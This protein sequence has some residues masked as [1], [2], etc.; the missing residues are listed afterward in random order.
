M[1]I[2]ALADIHGHT[3]QIPLLADAAGA[4]DAIVV[5]GDVTNFGRTSQARSV[6]SALSAFDR[7]VLGVSGN[8]D[9]PQV[10]DLL[11]QQ[12]G[13]L[14]H[15]PVELN[16]IM[17]VG[18]S[19]NGT[20]GAVLPNESILRTASAKPV[21]LVTHQPA[22]GTAVDLQVAT[23]HKGS[24]SVRSFIEDYQPL[25]AVS[26]HIHEAR[27]TDQLGSTLLVNPGPFRNGCYAIIDIV[28]NTAKATL[29]VL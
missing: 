17:Y 13:G 20:S 29:C 22:W 14:V 25:L 2:L 21:I 24:I 9:P 3:K 8:C 26:G 6:L 23:R 28:N 27:G 5:A 7:P 18:F 11:K 1:K 15:G 12:G 10:D 16:G 19:Y 4:C